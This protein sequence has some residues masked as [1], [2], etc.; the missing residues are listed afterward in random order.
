MSVVV[1]FAK[2][3]SFA[4]RT[5]TISDRRSYIAPSDFPSTPPTSPTPTASILLSAK[6]VANRPTEKRLIRMKG[7]Q[8]QVVAT[9]GAGPQD[10]L[11]VLKQATDLWW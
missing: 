5:A 2:R 3:H 10:Q 9:N 11:E 8:T 4:E 1:C 6:L 7:A